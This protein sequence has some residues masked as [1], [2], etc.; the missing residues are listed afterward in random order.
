[1]IISKHFQLTVASLLYR[2]V[3][4]GPV[5]VNIDESVWYQVKSSEEAVILCKT[6]IGSLKLE[7]NDLPATKV[8]FLT[9]L[10]RC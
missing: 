10:L 5:C 3:S 6:S 9:S 4:A 7:I 1:M 2:S 8:N